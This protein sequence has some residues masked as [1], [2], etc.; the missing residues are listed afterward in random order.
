M[1]YQNWKNSKDKWVKILSRVRDK[2]PWDDRDGWVD[3]KVVEK[4]GF[5]DEYFHC[6]EI[7]PL[8]PTFCGD[9]FN[10]SKKRGE[11]LSIFWEF[12]K[13]FVWEW[14]R[15]ETLYIEEEIEWIEAEKL[16]QQMIEEIDKY[17]P[18]P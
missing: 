14:R 12:C 17:E 9:S 10:L 16:C 2:K 1:N 8:L 6:C 5:C 7:C 3:L 4:C 11:N 18:K 13:I 15:P